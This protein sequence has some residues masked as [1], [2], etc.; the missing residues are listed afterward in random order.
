M[1]SVLTVAVALVTPCELTLA[2]E[3]GQRRPPVI[4]GTFPLL[5]VDN[6]S[7][8]PEPAVD[9]AAM[10]SAMA[11]NKREGFGS[12]VLYLVFYKFSL[13]TS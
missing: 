10:G 1:P 2:L 12:T 9:G 4:A 13:E 6:E 8:A 7:D 3:A 11:P 5:S